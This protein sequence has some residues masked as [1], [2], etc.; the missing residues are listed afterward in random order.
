VSFDYFILAFLQ[1]FDQG[2][3]RTKLFVAIVSLLPSPIVLFVAMNG[4]NNTSLI[5][6]SFP[7][8]GFCA[9]R[10]LRTKSYKLP[11]PKLLA[12]RLTT[13]S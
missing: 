5:L 1:N 8:P 13:I 6:V 10:Q 12:V 2:H 4:C 11:H 3:Q 9:A 7:R